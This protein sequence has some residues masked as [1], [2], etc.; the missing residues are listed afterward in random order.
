MAVVVVRIPGQFR[1]V[2]DG[3][4]NVTLSGNTVAE[5]FAGLCKNYFFNF[6]EFLSYLIRKKKCQ[7]LHIGQIRLPKG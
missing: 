5:V 3:V 2:A 4:S 6:R 1:S 7:K